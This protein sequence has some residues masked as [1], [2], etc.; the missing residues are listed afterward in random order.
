MGPSP[1]PNSNPRLVEPINR[2]SPPHFLQIQ[3]FQN[4][5]L[6]LQGASS[7][8][9]RRIKNHRVSKNR[10]QPPI[11]QEQGGFIVFQLIL[12]HSGSSGHALESLKSLGD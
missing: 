5:K 6:R 7:Y 11:D 1:K 10:S 12:Q 2:G 4:S 3:Y 8:Q 9:A